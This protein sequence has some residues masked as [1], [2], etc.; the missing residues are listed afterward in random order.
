MA[1]NFPVNWLI[2]AAVLATLMALAR[3]METLRGRKVVERDPA[4]GEVIGADTKAVWWLLFVLAWAVVM[5]VLMAWLTFA[6]L[7]NQVGNRYL[8][9]VMLALALIDLIKLARF[10]RPSRQENVTVT[11]DDGNQVSGKLTDPGRDVIGS[12]PKPPVYMWLPLRLKFWYQVAY[13]WYLF[14]VVSH[15][16]TDPNLGFLPG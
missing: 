10:I 3:P 1:G 16:L 8:G 15:V 4:T 2:V 9:L 5:V 12:G 7:L 14:L 11:T 6:A 13:L